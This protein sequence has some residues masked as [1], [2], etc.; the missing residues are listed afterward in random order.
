MNTRK[1]RQIIVLSYMLCMCISTAFAQKAAPQMVEL[2]YGGQ[3]ECLR[4]TIHTMSE[5]N[6]ATV[7]VTGVKDDPE[8]L[9]ENERVICEEDGIRIIVKGEDITPDTKKEVIRQAKAMMRG[10]RN[11]S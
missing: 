6:V 7:R 3:M 8:I 4:G 5:K 2:H 9:G 11:V 1:M 10:K